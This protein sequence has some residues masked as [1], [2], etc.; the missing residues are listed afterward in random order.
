MSSP[1]I[2]LVPANG[3]IKPRII[4]VDKPISTSE[5]AWEGCTDYFVDMTRP[6]QITNWRILS[7]PGW[8]NLLVD[9]N[10]EVDAVDDKSITFR[11]LEKA[12]RVKSIKLEIN[13]DGPAPTDKTFESN[14]WA[15][16][17]LVENVI[18]GAEYECRARL[19]EDTEGGKEVA[20]PWTKGTKVNTTEE[21]PQ[22]EIGEKMDN[23]AKAQDEEGG[24]G[25][26]PT[27][28]GIGCICVIVALVVVVVCR[29]KAAGK[30][31][32]TKKL[33]TRTLKFNDENKK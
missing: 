25:I 31:V 23:E 21:A 2:K 9:W 3:H 27:V 20:G 6:S 22:E 13:C 33:N 24:A 1:S 16:D 12:C 11:P 32:T 5:V 26:A 28:V 19:L 8:K 14:R 29:R 17:L 4:S 15:E 7:H 30:K 18:G 10:L